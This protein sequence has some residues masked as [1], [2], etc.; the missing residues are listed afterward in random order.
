MAGFSEIPRASTLAAE[1]TSQIE[2]RILNG[3]L[4]PGSRLPSERALAHQFGVSRTVIREAVRALSARNLL[5]V[6]SGHGTIIRY[7]EN[8][9]VTA[10]LSRLLR[11][12]TPDLD[13]NKVN[14]IRR[15]LE[16]KIASLAAER[17]DESDID[18]I[19]EILDRS[20]AST[21]NS[22]SFAALDVGF[23]SALARATHNELFSILLDATVDVMLNVR[24]LAVHAVRGTP[25]RALKMHEAIF[26]AVRA[27]DGLAAAAAMSEHLDESEKTM[28]SALRTM[29]R[30][31]APDD[32]AQDDTFAQ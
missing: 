22:D 1:V 13:Y 11:I 9:S 5:E 12:G 3:S 17:R 4:L 32:E 10:P 16:V 30:R 15:L 24:R 25:R 18:G 27:G 8:D 29:K 19:S 2:R 23:H 20:R 6:K 26:E 31:V 21:D 7:P 28:S 14:E